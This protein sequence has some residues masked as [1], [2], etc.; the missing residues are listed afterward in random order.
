[1]Q[2]SGSN[3]V[4]MVKCTDPPCTMPSCVLWL[5]YS[6]SYYNDCLCE[7]VFLMTI[8]KTPYYI[9][10]RKQWIIWLYVT[11]IRPI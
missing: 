4:C 1:M 5:K 2:A 8:Y 9:I 11:H 6:D 3:I 10:N 7:I